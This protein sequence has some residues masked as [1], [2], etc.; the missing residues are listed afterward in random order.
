MANNPLEKARQLQRLTTAVQISKIC[1]PGV[2][3]GK[4]LGSAKRAIGKSGPPSVNAMLS[5]FNRTEAGSA[6]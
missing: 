6:R 2:L 1:G 4:A 3:L 5:K